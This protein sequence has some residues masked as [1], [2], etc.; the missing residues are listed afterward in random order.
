MSV[1]HDNNKQPYTGILVRNVLYLPVHT[2]EK[3]D[4]CWT[5]KKDDKI[6]SDSNSQSEGT[7][8]HQPIVLVE[9]D[10][11]DGSVGNEGI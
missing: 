11:D 4:Y 6:S 2:F 7:R 3:D 8:Y 9:E 1:N 10:N 5:S